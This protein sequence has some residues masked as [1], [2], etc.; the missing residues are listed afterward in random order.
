M[1]SKTF[2]E[3][4]ESKIGMQGIHFQLT[5]GLQAVIREKFARLLTR[6][7]HILRVDIRVHQDQKVG[8]AHHYTATG[9]VVIA[10]PDLIAS[11]E[12]SEVYGLF[13]LLVE[14]LEHLVDRRH[15]KRKDHRNHP[16]AVELDAEIPKTQLV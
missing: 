1:K 7:D 4:A 3:S 14:K 2:F 6:N 10:G 15:G 9:Q 5:E 11:V 8:S 13:D 16:K 12:G